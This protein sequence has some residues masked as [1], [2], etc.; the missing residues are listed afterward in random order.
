MGTLGTFFA[1][2]DKGD[3]FYGFLCAFLYIYPERNECFPFRVD[4]FS[5]GKHNIFEGVA[6]FEGRLRDK[7]GSS[8]K[9]LRE[10]RYRGSVISDV[11]CFLL[12]KL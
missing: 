8:A 1:I 3:N 2:F 12:W 9:R 4:P 5:E 11:V 10:E 6:S 7:F